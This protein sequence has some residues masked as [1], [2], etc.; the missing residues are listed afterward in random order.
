[1]LSSQKQ[2]GVKGLSATLWPDS[3][4][5]CIHYS[6]LLFSKSLICF[7][8]SIKNADTDNTSFTP[9]EE[10]KKTPLIQRGGRTWGWGAAGEDE[11]LS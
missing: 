9:E 7:K 10:R 1:M 8:G 3:V 5:G 6:V 11:S 2:S 4:E